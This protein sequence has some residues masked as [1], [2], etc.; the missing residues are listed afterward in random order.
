M[1]FEVDIIIVYVD[2]LTNFSYFT[3]VH[4]KLNFTH[5]WYLNCNN[6]YLFIRLIDRSKRIYITCA[7]L[8]QYNTYGRVNVCVTVPWM[9]LV[10]TPFASSTPEHG[11]WV[12]D[13][14]L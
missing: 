13:R 8:T 6:R 5:C 11:D 12:I 14:V 2:S 1:P 4:E 10:Q 7:S 9:V 3:S